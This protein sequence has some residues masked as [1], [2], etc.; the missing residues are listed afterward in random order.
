MCHYVPEETMKVADTFLKCKGVPSPHLV[1]YQHPDVTL[2]LPILHSALN[3]WW[4]MRQSRSLFFLSWGYLLWGHF[5]AHARQGCSCSTWIRCHCFCRLPSKRL[6]TVLLKSW[7][8]VRWAK[9]SKNHVICKNSMSSI[10]GC[11]A[12]SILCRAPS[13]RFS[14]IAS[15]SDPSDPSGCGFW[16]SNRWLTEKANQNH[17]AY[18]ASGERD[19]NVEKVEEASARTQIRKDKDIIIQRHSLPGPSHTGLNALKKS[20]PTSPDKFKSVGSSKWT[21]RGNPSDQHCTDTS[22]WKKLKEADNSAF[23]PHFSPDIEI[24]FASNARELP[25]GAAV[26]FYICWCLFCLGLWQTLCHG[27][28]IPAHS[29][30]PESS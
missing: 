11:P 10:A 17:Y 23:L 15:A 8:L 12:G 3:K 19:Y 27:R 7:P 22:W 28:A 26:S 18:Y 14:S 25:K 29:R 30:H 16:C 13:M 5:T 24:G 6:V 4:T 20:S 2:I 1:V 9:C 21:C